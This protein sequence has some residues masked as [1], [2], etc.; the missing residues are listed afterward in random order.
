MRGFINLLPFLFL[1]SC[2]RWSDD[3]SIRYLIPEESCYVDIGYKATGPAWKDREERVD[4][5]IYDNERTY[6]ADEQGRCASSNIHIDLELMTERD[7]PQLYP[8]DQA[9]WDQCCD[10]IAFPDYCSKRVELEWFS[11]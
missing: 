6:Y 8:C 10:G 9:D 7:S 1:T 11:E 3:V 5:E 2:L 4:N